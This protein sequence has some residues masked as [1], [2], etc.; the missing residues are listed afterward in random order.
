MKTSHA[1]ALEEVTHLFLN[2]RKQPKGDQDA[3][4]D[5]LERRMTQLFEE[6]WTRKELY[7]LASEIMTSFSSLPEEHY[8]DVSNYLD[9]LIGWVATGCITRFPGE[10]TDPD[11][12]AAYVLGMKWL[13]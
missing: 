7:H 9:G 2:I 3:G 13:E 8:D 4:W 5:A 6:G 12:L 1:Q 10:P 11:E